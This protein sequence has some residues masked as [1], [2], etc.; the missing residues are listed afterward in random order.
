[1]IVSRSVDILPMDFNLTLSEEDELVKSVI[2][3][4]RKSTKK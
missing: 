3:F 2:N 4:V 1:M